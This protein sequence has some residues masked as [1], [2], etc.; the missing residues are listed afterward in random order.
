MF[1]LLELAVVLVAGFVIFSFFRRN[2]TG[3]REAVIERRVEAYMHTIRREARNPELAAM[4]DLELKDLL[5]S[6]ARNLKIDA[7]RRTFALMGASAGA[8]VIALIIASQDG[9][10]G[11]GIALLVAAIAIYGLSEFLSRRMRE[12]LRARGIDIERLRVE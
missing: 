5:L 10:R 1:A 9:W 2:R 6:S 11:F 12:P 3:E 8:V 7:E 4:T